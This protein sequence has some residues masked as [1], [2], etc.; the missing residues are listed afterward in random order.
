M[1]L[2]PLA[3]CSSS[4][5]SASEVC[6]K[7][8]AAGV[9]SGCR[10]AKPA[11]LG[12]AAVESVEFDLIGVPGKKGAVMR[13]DRESFFASTEEAF[14]KMAA[15]AGPHRYGSRRALVFVQANSDLSLED[16]KKIKA[17][18]DSL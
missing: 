5:P 2:L 6:A 16:G 10:E 17:I 14:G 1:A 4:R 7:I 12:A 13:F 3:S 15:L 9:A 18:V 11:G 8:V